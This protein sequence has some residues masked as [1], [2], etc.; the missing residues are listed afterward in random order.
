MLSWHWTPG[1]GGLLA[2]VEVAEVA[3]HLPQSMPSDGH[4]VRPLHLTCLRGQSMAPLV[5]LLPELPEL[6]ELPGSCELSIVRPTSGMG[7][8]WFCERL[9]GSATRTGTSGV[10]RN[11]GHPA[12]LVV[13]SPL[14]YLPRLSARNR[15]AVE[16]GAR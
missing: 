16:K 14:K 4:P 10:G 5:G 7:E 9:Y 1:A 8:I 3:E 13:S 2:L 15:C 12:G 6:P 11:R